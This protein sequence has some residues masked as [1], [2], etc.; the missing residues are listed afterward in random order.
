MSQQF[1]GDAQDLAAGVVI[2]TTTET[3]GP[4]TNPLPLPF[5]TG[6]FRVLAVCFIATGTGVTAV[7]LRIRR[8]PNAENVTVNGTV[9]N[10]ITPAST[11]VQVNIGVVD[12]I[13]DGRP[14]SYA[15]TVTQVGATGNG[16]FLAGS[17]IEAVAMSG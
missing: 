13:S 16:T 7:Q 1:L 12:P 17:H 2:N 10:V 4:T 5:Q 6:K 11:V 14:C 3:T 15:V 8:N 9:S